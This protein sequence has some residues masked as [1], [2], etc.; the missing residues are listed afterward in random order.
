ME[1]SR[2]V[3]PEGMAQL[4][5]V[6]QHILGPEPDLEWQ[7]VETHAVFNADLLGTVPDGETWTVEARTLG[8]P[9][10][11]ARPFDRTLERSVLSTESNG[12][13]WKR[14]IGNKTAWETRLP[15]DVPIAG[16]LGLIDALQRHPRGNF[17]FPEFGVIKQGTSW[18]P[19][20]QI[21]ALPQTE[22]HVNGSTLALHGYVQTGRAHLPTFFWFD[23][24]NRLVALRYG[25]LALLL[26]PQPFM[27][28][29]CPHAA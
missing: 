8:Q 14:S 4:H 26:S 29:R 15:A 20:Q 27:K 12:R 17:K 7:R 19:A 6:Q 28:S 11:A 25:V 18:C 16:S 1:I 2:N 10:P 3:L 24:A 13:I 21:R 9:D 23:A 5:A 22:L